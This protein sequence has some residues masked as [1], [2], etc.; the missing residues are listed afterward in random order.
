MSINSE[1]LILHNQKLD[2]ALE[3]ANNFPLYEDLTELLNIQY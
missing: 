2:L 3:T 1:R